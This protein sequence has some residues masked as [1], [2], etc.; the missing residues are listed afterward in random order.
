M[1]LYCESNDRFDYLIETEEID[2]RHPLIEQA[3]TALRTDSMTETEKV[4]TTFEFVRDEISHSWDLQSKRI[5]RTASEAMQHKEG[6]CYAKSNL[7]AALLRVQGI[8]TGFCYQ[9][10][11]IG[12]TPD[13]GYCIHA[14]NGVYLSAE[15]K[16]IRLDA[17]GNKAG[18]QA[19]F[20]V[21][22]E[23][24]AFP[25]RPQYGERD[26]PVIYTRP[27]N[28]TMKALQRNSDCL[29]MYLHDLPKEL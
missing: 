17:R 29:Y 1:R 7:L 20:D 18:V 5:T 11:T 22:A 9:R 6:I 21:N 3:V 24:L 19:E 27:N 12:D 28:K 16:W 13:T 14:L 25:V 8:P 2:Y 4:K 26:Y 15:Q 10:L 23:K